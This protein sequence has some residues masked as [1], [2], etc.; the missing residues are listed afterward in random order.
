MNGTVHNRPLDALVSRRA[1]APARPD[2]R[3]IA[4][5]DILT[6]GADV[7]AQPGAAALEAAGTM[8]AA[9]ADMYALAYGYGGALA[10]PAGL[11]V[12]AR[13]AAALERAADAE[14]L[15]VPKG[16]EHAAA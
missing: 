5:G 12:L 15:E 10:V 7:A 11:R 9:A 8:N 16:G 6:H 4:L 13:V 3:L 2:R 14:P 1:H